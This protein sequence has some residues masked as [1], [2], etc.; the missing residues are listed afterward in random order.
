MDT[1]LAQDERAHV[2]INQGGQKEVAFGRW[3]E[4]HL[5]CT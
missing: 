2:K 4:G 3:K 1:V 5:D